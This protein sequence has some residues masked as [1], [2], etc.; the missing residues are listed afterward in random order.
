MFSSSTLPTVLTRRLTV[1]RSPPAASFKMTLRV[2][3]NQT[4]IS[5]ISLTSAGLRR[6]AASVGL[7]HVPVG[8]AIVQQELL[9]NL[10]RTRGENA[11]AT[12]AQSANA[13]LREAKGGGRGGGCQGVVIRM[14]ALLYSTPPASPSYK[15]GKLAV[16][17]V[18]S[19]AAI[20]VDEAHLVAQLRKGGWGGGTVRRMLTRCNQNRQC[21]L[22]RR[23]C[24]AAG[25]PC[26]R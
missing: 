17:R 22:F 20:V 3:H 2:R 15:A 26:A 13:R 7:K 8:L 5:S 25:A 14:T 18:V 23:Q 6:V 11:D 24:P 9:A 16:G 4:D 19:G 10:H 12:L 1:L 21:K